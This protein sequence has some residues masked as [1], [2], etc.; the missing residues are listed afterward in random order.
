MPDI[1]AI[2]YGKNGNENLEGNINVEGVYVLSESFAYSGE[3]YQNIYEVQEILGDAVYEGN[4]YITMPEAVAIH[5]LNEK[6]NEF[7]GD[8]KGIWNENLADVIEVEKYDAEYTF[9]LYTYVKDNLR[10]TFFAKDRTGVFS[11]YSIEQE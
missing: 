4:A 10:Y 8:V 9:Y 5:V 11:M 6:G 7:Y 3:T 2:Y 1:G